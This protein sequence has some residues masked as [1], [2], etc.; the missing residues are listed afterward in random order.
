MVLALGTEIDRLHR[1]IEALRLQQ[2]QLLR[3]FEALTAGAG[4]PLS[5]P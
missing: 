4:T 5:A 2:R 1:R 3:R